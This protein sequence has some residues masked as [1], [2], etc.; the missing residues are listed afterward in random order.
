MMTENLSSA[1]ADFHRARRQATLQQIMAHLTGR[2]ADLLSYDDVRR[3][4]RARESSASKLQDIPLDAIV[5]SVG[6]YTD[7]TRTFLPRLDSDRQRW[8]RVK[9]ATT[10]MAGLP[11]IEVYQIGEA[12]FVRD[13]NHRVSVARQLGATH[14][15]AYVTQ[16]HT[17]IPLS[18]DVQ[19]DDLI[20]KAGYATFLERTHLDELRPEADLSVTVPGQYEVLQEHIEIHRY[21]MGLD[22][23]RDIPFEEAV[24]HFYDT[25]YLPIAQVIREQ[26]ILRDFPHRTEADLYLWLSEHRAALA[27]EL[28]WDI[29]PE[30]AAADLAAQFSST[31][32]RVMARV[33]ERIL[34]AVTPAELESGPPPGQWREER[35]ATTADDRLFRDALVAITGE[36][37]GWCALEQALIL[38]HREDM[39]LHGLYVVPL[40]GEHGSEDV[41]VV[42]AR[43]N[44]RCEAAGVQGSLTIT[45]GDVARTVCDRARWTDL[46]ILS[47]SH[48]PAP[49]PLARLSS[50]FHTIVRLCP[51]PVLAVPGTPSELTHA[52]L[53]YDGSPKAD[54]ALYI[55]TYMANRW[56]I[57]LVV[58]TVIETGRTT[59]AALERA[60][61]YLDSHGV[62]LLLG[63]RH[64][65]GAQAT[66]VEESGPVPEAILKTA[67]SHGCDLILMG[68]Y[69]LSPVLE[70]VLG[71]AVDQ[72][73]RGSRMPVLI[74]R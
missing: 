63:R 34:D 72:V 3:K 23:Q 62:P 16:V 35:A 38:A 52:L 55:A 10:D 14:I 40:E 17:R 66:Y 4:L 26:G 59:S 65:D 61:E 48:P 51:R 43:F 74:C 42:Q 9:R 13:G 70:V 45:T 71:S 32:K 60:R 19:P 20:L 73:L 31:P 58:V 36:E 53:A 41:Q 69:G 7:F 67:E 8:A 47:L 15:Q 12:Y 28:G 49:E 37:N 39:H 27:G 50:G 44:R 21:F 30:D 29:K 6:R 25:V 64:S 33:G 68:G 11:P 57:P 24:T 46:A 22:L 2:S 1:V 54:E 5:G 56:S 18:P